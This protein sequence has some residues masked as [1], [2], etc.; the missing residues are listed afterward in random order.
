MPRHFPS[1]WFSQLPP[2]EAARFVVLLE[3]VRQGDWLRIARTPDGRLALR[4][5]KTPDELFL[6]G[7]PDE[8][9]IT[10]V[11]RLHKE[12]SPPIFR[13]FKDDRTFGSTILLEAV[14]ALLDDDVELTKGLLRRTVDAMVGFELLAQAMEGHPKS[15]VR[16]LSPNGNPSAKHLAAILTRL[17]QLQ[18]VRFKISIR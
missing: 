15:L 5:G 9:L 4:R 6:F 7:D 1:S 10:A 17:A 14:R 18:G 12:T 8:G 3:R 2:A 16:M 13:R 11:R